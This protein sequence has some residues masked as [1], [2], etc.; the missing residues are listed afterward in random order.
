MVLPRAFANDILNA[1]DVIILNNVIDAVNSGNNPADAF[2]GGDKFGA[3]ATVAVQRLLWPQNVTSSSFGGNFSTVLAGA[4]EVVD[5]FEYGTAFTA[6]IGE[7]SD[8]RSGNSV[9]EEVRAFVTAA[10]NGTEIFLNGTSQG[11]IN[12]G[13]TLVI[14]GIN[15]GDKITTT[16]DKPVEAHLLTGDINGDFESRSYSLTRDSD[17]GNDYYSPVTVTTGA[18]ACSPNRVF[19][20]QSH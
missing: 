2:N 12:E 13:E 17:L 16:P 14:D 5:T 15:E 19:C 9:F 10:E 3:T 8:S 11:T 1:G 7:N 4:V 20:S 18:G 6:P